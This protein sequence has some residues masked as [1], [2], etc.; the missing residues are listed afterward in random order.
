MKIHKSIY[1]VAL[2]FILFFYTSPSLAQTI[3]LDTPSHERPVIVEKEYDFSKTN[4]NDS[5][6]QQSNDNNMQHLVYLGLPIALAS[7]ILI[8]FILKRS[9]KKN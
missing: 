8:V 9:R 6:P 4:Q 2:V 3:T 7:I 5:S 1:V